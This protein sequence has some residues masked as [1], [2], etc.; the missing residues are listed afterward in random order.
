MALLALALPLLC[1]SAVDYVSKLQQGLGSAAI[2][3]KDLDYHRAIDKIDELSTLLS[4]WRGALHTAATA[5]AAAP[6]EDAEVVRD[7][8]IEFSV[9]VTHLPERCQRKSHQGATMKV[10]Y[11]GK[12]SRTGKMFAS[13]FHTGSQP[14]RFRLGSDE[15]IGAWNQGL[16][17]MC[18]GERRRLLVPWQMAYGE[19]GAKGVPAFAN[20]QYDFELV[21]LMH[22]K[23]GGESDDA[24]KKGGKGKAE[25]TRKKKQKRKDEV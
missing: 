17:A 23:L 2:A 3:A 11:V 20:L 16:D 21:E 15:V 14:F 24:D 13:S 9:N 7:E 1:V 18:E 10:H 5:P 22:V 4:E 19:A 6:A 8:L 12:V 25:K